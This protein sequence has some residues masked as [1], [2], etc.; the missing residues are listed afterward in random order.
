MRWRSPVF[1]AAVDSNTQRL[2]R[3]TERVVFPLDTNEPTHVARMGNFH[4]LTVSPS[5]SWV[6]VG[7]ERPADAWKS[8]LLIARIRWSKPNRI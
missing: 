2:I 8:D 1:I 5:E 6:T 3:A 4:T 7:E